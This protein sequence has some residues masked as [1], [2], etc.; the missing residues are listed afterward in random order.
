MLIREAETD[1]LTILA[2]AGVASGPITPGD[3][4]TI[5]EVF[6]GFATIPA[7]AARTCR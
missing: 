2:D 7:D 3:V 1:L 5:G 4:G 6:R